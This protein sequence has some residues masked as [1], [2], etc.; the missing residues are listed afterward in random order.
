[1]SGVFYIVI[2]E[3]RGP[4]SV[5]FRHSAQSAAIAEANRLASTHG[6]TFLVLEAQFEV[7]RQDIVTRRLHD[8]ME[9]P[10]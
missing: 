4:S 10:F 8:D 7:K 3:Q 2:S 1:M 6:G 9:I 5:P